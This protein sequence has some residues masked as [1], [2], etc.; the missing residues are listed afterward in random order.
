LPSTK[1]SLFP[2]YLENIP[3]YSPIIL[4]FQGWEADTAHNFIKNNVDANQ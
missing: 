3:I 2:S 4:K 1:E